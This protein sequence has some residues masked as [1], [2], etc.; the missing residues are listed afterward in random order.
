MR[1]QLDLF[2]GRE[3][4]T[5]GDG[6]LAVFD[7]PVRAVKCAAAM[8][9]AVTDLGISIRAGLHTG[10]IELVAG[11]PRGVAVHTAARIAALAGP[12]E[13]LLSGT[14]RDLLEGA[15]L[16]FE[17]RGTH[18]FKGLATPRQVFALVRVVRTEGSA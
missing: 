11:N 18:E 17:D 2:R 6:I 16:D 1:R 3:V 8:G 12:D 15:G 13:V 14:T 9:P 4:T 5:T 10:E 7:T